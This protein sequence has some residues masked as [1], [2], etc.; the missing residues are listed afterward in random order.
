MGFSL[1]TQA[2][3]LFYFANKLFSLF[4]KITVLNINFRLPLNLY[5]CLSSSLRLFHAIPTFLLIS[6]NSKK[7][8]QENHSGNYMEKRR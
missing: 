8:K 3:V 6:V 5:T 4:A 7:T 2:T 1:C